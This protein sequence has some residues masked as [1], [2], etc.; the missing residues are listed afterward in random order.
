MTCSGSHLRHEL[1]RGTSLQQALPALK[2]FSL[3]SFIG[4]KVFI[5]NSTCV[6]LLLV[7]HKAGQLC[8]DVKI[9]SCAHRP[10]L[11]PSVQ[12]TPQFHVPPNQ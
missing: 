6:W 1:G 2:L 5:C 4:W 11:R 9:T 8:A 12:A 7:T 3:F 10:S